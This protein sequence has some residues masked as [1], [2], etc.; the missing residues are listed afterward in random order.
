MEPNNKVFK[1]NF[2]TDNLRI[3]RDAV[4]KKVNVSLNIEH[5]KKSM[6]YMAWLQVCA[7]MDRLDDTV[8]YLNTMELGHDRKSRSAFD[9]YE[10]VNNA[11]IVINCIQKIAQIYRIDNSKIKNIESKQDVFGDVMNV[12][13]NDSKFFSYIRSLCAVHPVETD[14]Q[15]HPYLS[16]RSAAL[17][18]CPYVIWEGVLPFNKKDGRDLTVWIYEMK[19]DMT[20]GQLE[21][22]IYVDQF[23]QYVNKWINFIPDII[24]AI[25]N[26]SEEIY[27]GFRNVQLKTIEEFSNEIEYLKYLKEV[28]IERYGN[29]F[30]YIYDQYIR[31]FETKITD[32]KN[33]EKVEKYKNAIRYSL[34]FLHNSLQNMS[35]EGFENTGIENDGDSEGGGDL[36]YRLSS[37][38]YGNEEFKSC[39]DNFSK[40]YELEKNS[41]F[42]HDERYARFL[43]EEVKDKINKYV[44]FTNKESNDE[45]IVLVNTALYLS[46][47]NSRCVL[48]R[49]IPNELPYR[50]NILSQTKWKWIH[51]KKRVKRN[52]LFEDYLIKFIDKNGNI[53]VK[54]IKDL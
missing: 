15:S 7:I 23:E 42:I 35:E 54:K 1:F 29:D 28:Q 48:N 14:H 22:P 51:T 32:F 44:V 6:K 25:H 31:V 18:V 45:T 17:H 3:L 30:S 37:P 4:N 38:L 39:N 34:T 24:D 8:G 36:F 19:K 52:P 26:Y 33:I 11:Y 21:I 46:C 27:E 47:L 13:G 10:F 2:N 40:L 53:E 12:G 50:M 9:F 43:L 5:D 16:K 20:M 41:D 49:N